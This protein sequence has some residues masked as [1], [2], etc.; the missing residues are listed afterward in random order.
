MVSKLSIVYQFKRDGKE[1][2]ARGAKLCLVSA[3]INK[4]A[5]TA[6]HQQ[7]VNPTHT[8]SNQQ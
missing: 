8:F 2:N 4:E 7:Y 3:L 6:L 1:R 5:T